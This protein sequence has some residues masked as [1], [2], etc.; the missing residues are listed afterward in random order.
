ML[1]LLII[2]LWVVGMSERF[3][4]AYYRFT[5]S[6]VTVF[7][8]AFAPNNTAIDILLVFC[9]RFNDELFEIYAKTIDNLDKTCFMFLSFGTNLS[10]LL[11]MSCYTFQ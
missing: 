2:H 6:Y 3:T 4:S 8:H 1:T 5:A 10:D 7:V 11:I 9:V